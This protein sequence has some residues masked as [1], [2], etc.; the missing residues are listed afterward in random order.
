MGVTGVDKRCNRRPGHRR[1]TKSSTTV[2]RLTFMGSVIT[3]YSYKGGAGRTMALANVAT[4][5]ASWQRKVL[6]IDWD[7][8]A[9]GIEHFFFG[10]EHLGKLQSRPGLVELLTKLNQSSDGMAEWESFMCL[11]DVTHDCRS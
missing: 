3:F 7:L 6:V 2:S 1:Q 5:L 10:S 11:C 8:E 4:L 9:P